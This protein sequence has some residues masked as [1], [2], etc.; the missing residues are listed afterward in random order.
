MCTLRQQVPLSLL[1]RVLPSG[2]GQLWRKVFCRCKHEQRYIRRQACRTA[3]ARRLTNVAPLP[4][5]ID[6]YMVESNQHTSPRPAGA[7]CGR[8]HARMWA[9]DG[10]RGVFTLLRNGRRHPCR[11][12]LEPSE[13]R[14]S[15]Q[16][17]QH[18]A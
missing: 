14:T 18:A 2:A 15:A 7:P 6:L 12:R 11:L 4:L 1:D 17:S 5:Y 8:C 3:I 9:P 10:R 13:P 16:H